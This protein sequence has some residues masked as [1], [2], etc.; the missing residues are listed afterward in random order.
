MIKYNGV[1]TYQVWTCFNRKGEKSKIVTRAARITAKRV[2][3]MS[4]TW[5]KSGRDVTA[6]FPGKMAM[7]LLSYQQ[8][9][10]EPVI[11]PSKQEPSETS[12]AA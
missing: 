6:W 5:D 3:T 8:N 4:R 11:L 2:Q 9:G 12:C 1:A 10:R 7:R